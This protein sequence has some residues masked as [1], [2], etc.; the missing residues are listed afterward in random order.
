MLADRA[1]ASTRLTLVLIGRSEL[2]DR[3]GADGL[4]ST[5]VAV[6]RLG[7]LSASECHEI[8]TERGPIDAELA[9]DI[10]RQCGGNP[11]FLLEMLKR[12][13]L[14]TTGA[15]AVPDTV[16]S[17]L[18]EKFDLL[19][20]PQ[21]ELLRIMAVLGR[22]A[23]PQVLASAL[24]AMA[25]DEL[26][27]CAAALVDDGVLRPV[28]E[29]A[30][31]FAHS[32]VQTVVYSAM[33][34]TER[35]QR[36]VRIAESLWQ[37]NPADV[38]FD[39]VAAHL[40]EAIVL[41]NQMLVPRPLQVSAD[42]VMSSFML[43]TRRA[44]HQGRL[45]D[46]ADLVRTV[47]S[48]EP[49]LG[50]RATLL[51]L[52]G[53]VLGW[54]PGAVNAYRQLLVL[55]AGDTVA[56]APAGTELR[57]LRKLIAVLTRGGQLGRL[58][59]PASELAVLMD[60]AFELATTTTDEAERHHVNVLRCFQLPEPSADD[61]HGSPAELSQIL[62]LASRAADHFAAD[63]DT[64]HLNASLD[65]CQ[66]VAAR[67]GRFG[68]A[69]EIAQ[70][71]L[72][73]AGLGPT[74]RADVISMA[75]TAHW[76]A[77][78]PSQAITLIEQ[79]IATRPPTQPIGTLGLAIAAG[80]SVAY[81]AGLWQRALALRPWLDA[82]LQN[83]TSLRQ[84]PSYCIDGYFS[85]LWIA[86]AGG[87]DAQ[88]LTL[89]DVIRSCMTDVGHVTEELEEILALGTAAP[90]PAGRPLPA[91]PLS[92]P[93]LALRNERGLRSP[94]PMIEKVA[95]GGSA[96]PDRPVDVALAIARSDTRALAALADEFQDR[97]M[98]TLALRLRLAVTSMADD[99]R[100]FAEAAAALAEIGDV[101]TARWFAAAADP[102]AEGVMA[103]G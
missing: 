65:G 33:A 92:A 11:F 9:T 103:R 8:V 13:R 94:L 10:V 18:L 42:M 16:H 67:L 2:L 35:T 102:S 56:A 82:A 40:S 89:A 61:R 26:L 58:A 31:A 27:R 12:A 55:V 70:R 4:K 38:I 74:E 57:A 93:L 100:G 77:R 60:R 78:Q 14:G 69:L 64:E 96:R 43:A 44:W 1:E 99:P 59:F 98:V 62:E 22:W 24:P 73:L 25:E 72:R 34:R 97:G 39:E 15:E 32:L 83:I 5:P 75:V 46:A 85:L 63:G 81:Q 37:H 68:D 53:D 29:G 51:E 21:R 52:L 28:A 101:R 30:P 48:L 6:Y 49:D 76:A 36:H 86:V 23:A 71:R 90:D 95:Q 54:S 91:A 66:V 84:D 41:T 19:P 45:S 20:A 17:V 3:L 88:I 7:P 80:L 87:D 79:E 47:L 50:R